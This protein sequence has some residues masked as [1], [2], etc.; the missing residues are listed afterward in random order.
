MG[1]PGSGPQKGGADKASKDARAATRLA[2]QDPSANRHRD[3]MVAHQKAADAHKE[4][5]SAGTAGEHMKHT[6][7]IEH[8]EKMAA[9]HDS[10]RESME[11]N[12]SSKETDPEKMK[13]GAQIKA[14]Q[15][16]AE[17]WQRSPAAGVIGNKDY[18]TSGK[19]GVPHSSPGVPGL[20]RGEKERM[21]DPAYAQK[22]GDLKSANEA[23]SHA[24]VESA[25][26]I[27][28]ET[29]EAH[30]IASRA[31]TIAAGK[32][33]QAGNPQSAERS[34]DMSR[35]HMNHAENLENGHKQSFSDTKKAYEDNKN[36]MKKSR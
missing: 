4:A 12:K 23:K 28:K 19:V 15:E 34:R 33:E 10:K 9:N 13:S 32:Q 16:K 35:I 22:V 31:H 5:R 7:A 1:G 21:K 8:H 18:M 20:N 25:T 26:A 2:K 29:P 17:A 11:P 14:E 3:A 30:Y 24:K 27:A 6:D 36:H